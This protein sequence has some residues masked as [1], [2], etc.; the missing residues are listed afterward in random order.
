MTD[1]SRR[2]VTFKTLE[3]IDSS[4]TLFNYSY[5]SIKVIPEPILRQIHDG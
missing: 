5:I 3:E 1:M 2:S 4:Y